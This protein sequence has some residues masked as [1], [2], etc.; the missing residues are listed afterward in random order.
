L[1]FR[2]GLSARLVESIVALG[3]SAGLDRKVSRFL[4]E[5]LSSPSVAF[6]EIAEFD[7]RS[8][9][10]ETRIIRL[11]FAIALVSVSDLSL[12]V[13]YHL[14]SRIILRNS[15]DFPIGSIQTSGDMFGRL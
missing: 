5:V 7:F 9:C 8:P 6:W 13:R 14:C 3:R 15:F 4:A 12:S 1:V 10:R 11:H 2:T